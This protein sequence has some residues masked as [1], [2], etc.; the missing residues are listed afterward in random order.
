MRGGEGRR[1]RKEADRYG[2]GSAPAVS[3][4]LVVL[5][6]VVG[7]GHGDALVLALVVCHL[8]DEQH[9]TPAGFP[10]VRG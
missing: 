9:G 7:D 4:L 5:G 8:E 10:T 1:G 6:R 2:G 3:G